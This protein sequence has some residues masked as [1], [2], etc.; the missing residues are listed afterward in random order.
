MFTAS[1]FRY[2]PMGSPVLKW[3]HGGLVK[4]QIPQNQITKRGGSY[5]PRVHFLFPRFCLCRS[6]SVNRRLTLRLLPG[7]LIKSEPLADDL[8]YCQIETLAVVKALAVVVAERLL[9]EVAEQVEGLYAHVGAA[10][11]ALQEAPE[12]L[13]PV[14]VDFAANVLY[15]VVNHFMLEFVKPFVRF[16]RVSEQSGAGENMFAYFGL[17]RLLLPIR[18]DLGNDLTAAL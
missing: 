13:Q 8:P 18:Y 12:V 14:G 5:P 1:L 2:A 6:F 15:R 16:Q 10:Q 11:P 17:K 7:E 9:I 3:N 4:A